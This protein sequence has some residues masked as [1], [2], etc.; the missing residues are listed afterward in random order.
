[1]A[2]IAMTARHQ[3]KGAQW[4]GRHDPVRIFVEELQMTN[5]NP[6]PKPDSGRPSDNAAPDPQPH[7]EGGMIDE[8][9]PTDGNV[10]GVENETE[11]RHDGAMLGEG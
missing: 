5:S 1:M 2:A 10:E 4:R 8:G 3:R 9:G 6:P 7:E 11:I